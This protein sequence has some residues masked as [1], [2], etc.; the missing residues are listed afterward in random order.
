MSKQSVELPAKPK[1]DYL[2]KVLLVGNSGVGKS[3]LLSRFCDDEYEITSMITI[4]VDFKIKTLPIGDK[5]ACLQ[6][7]DTAGN[8]RYRSITKSYYRGSQGAIVVYDITN[9]D[10][11][12][13]VDTWVDEITSISD[14]ITIILVGSKSDC[15][16]NR[17]VSRA[18]GEAKSQEIGCDFY[19]CSSKL[20]HNVTEIFEHLA[21]KISHNPSTNLIIRKEHP[22]TNRNLSLGKAEKSRTCMN[23][24]SCR[25][26]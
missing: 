20:G 8:K 22:S 1:Y 12:N 24:T 14:D 21:T 10:T 25:V 17:V 11:F 2:I 16:I 23:N 7:W 6:I 26:I 9:R 3:C 4:G 13:R 19:E 15:E 5:I 18:E